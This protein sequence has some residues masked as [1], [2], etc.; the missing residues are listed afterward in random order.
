MPV[1]IVIGL[2]AAGAIL[3]YGQV[4]STGQDSVTDLGGQVDATQSNATTKIAQAIA[5]AEGFYVDGS[6]PQRNHNPGDMTQDLTGT[7]VG[8]DGPF[9]V[10]ATDQDGWECLYAQVNAW[11]NGTSRYHSADS[12]INDLAGLGSET[13]YTATDQA[14][15]AATVASTLG[16]D[17]DTN[18]G[19]I[20]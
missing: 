20:V 16:V 18:L 10:Y 12:S 1:V 2:I 6:R 7:G 9:V 14:A 11:L 19:S 17:A 15:W 13:G 3:L 5:T 8:T 4:T